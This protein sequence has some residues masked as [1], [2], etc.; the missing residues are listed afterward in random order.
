MLCSMR[1]MQDDSYDAFHFNEN[2][3]MCEL[4]QYSNQSIYPNNNGI[5]VYVK[6]DIW[7]AASE[8]KTSELAGQK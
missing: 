7:L 3:T 1:C 6:W 8:G 5:E 4:G 2:D